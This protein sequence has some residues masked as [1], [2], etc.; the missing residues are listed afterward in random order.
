MVGFPITQRQMEDYPRN[1]GFLR[2]A[3]LESHLEQQ[4][5]IT[6]AAM[7]QFVQGQL[8]DEHA[9]LQQSV[10]ELYDRTA[11]IRAGFEIRDAEA[12]SSF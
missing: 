7:R 6:N 9:A 3:T 5:Y 2:S 10:Q 12:N 1:A 4:A 11:A 8:R